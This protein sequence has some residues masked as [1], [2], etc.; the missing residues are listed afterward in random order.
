MILWQF[1]DQ[2]NISEGYI[3]KSQVVSIDMFK[4]KKSWICNLEPRRRKVIEECNNAK[5]MH[6]ILVLGLRK[7]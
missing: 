2:R 7:E 3:F 6:F 1:K 4:K 5:H